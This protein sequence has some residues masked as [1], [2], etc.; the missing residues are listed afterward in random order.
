MKR[1]L[2]QIKMQQSRN[3]F[4]RNNQRWVFHFRFF[5]VTRP[6]FCKHFVE[7][8]PPSESKDIEPHSSYPVLGNRRMEYMKY[9]IGAKQ[10][11]I[12]ISRDN[13]DATTSLREGVHILA[14]FRV[15][16]KVQSTLCHIN[17]VKLCLGWIV[18]RII[19]SRS[20]EL[21]KRIIFNDQVLKRSQAY[22]KCRAWLI[23]KMPL[24][25]VN[26]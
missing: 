3:Y 2:K 26:W 16:T 4:S 15:G 19:A 10:F 23:C 25:Y 8:T 18:T 21:F 5:L 22:K 9:S 17:C 1:K 14:A 11:G 6:Y 24:K 7:C 20:E 13:I 12:I